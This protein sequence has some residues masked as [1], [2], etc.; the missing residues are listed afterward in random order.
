M[1]TNIIKKSLISFVYI[2]CIPSFHTNLENIY[3]GPF[4]CETTN[5]KSTLLLMMYTLQVELD[6]WKKSLFQNILYYLQKKIESPIHFLNKFFLRVKARLAM[7]AISTVNI[8][9]LTL[10]AECIALE[11]VENIG[12]N[13]ECEGGSWIMTYLEQN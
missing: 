6:A 7:W 1:Q 11:V 12:S 10:S 5:H 9:Q 4:Y 2:K 13:R 8:F 3:W